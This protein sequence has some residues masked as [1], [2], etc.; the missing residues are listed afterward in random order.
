MAT[1]YS[2][3]R[4]RTFDDCRLRYRYRY[5]EAIDAAKE[6]VEA[7]M[8]SRVHEALQELYG[9]IKNGVVKPPDWLLEI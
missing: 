9:F 5:I 4:I 7:F 2:I 6:T 8:G 1:V 3:S